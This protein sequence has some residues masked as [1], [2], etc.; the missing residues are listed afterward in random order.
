METVRDNIFVH[1]DINRNKLD[2]NFSHKK[3]LKKIIDAIFEN[4]VH[5]N[6]N[7]PIV[8]EREITLENGTSINYEVINT[9]NFHGFKFSLS[10]LI[11]VFCCKENPKDKHYFLFFGL[12]NKVKHFDQQENYQNVYLSLINF[13][14][15]LTYGNMITFQNFL[16]SNHIRNFIIRNEREFDRCLILFYP[17][18]PARN[19]RI[20]MFLQFM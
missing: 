13:I 17:D 4:K 1:I 8:F 2:R 20:K 6:L 19:D 10:D 15:D 7:L 16:I 14:N 9:E 5:F 3:I 18:Q 12:F 11:K